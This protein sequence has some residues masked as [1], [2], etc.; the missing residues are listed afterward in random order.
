MIALD[1]NVLA[2]YLVRD[3]TEQAEAARVAHG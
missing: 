2:R 1:T 3:N